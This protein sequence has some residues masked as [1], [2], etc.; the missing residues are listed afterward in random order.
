MNPCLNHLY[1]CRRL[2]RYVNANCGPTADW[3][4]DIVF[5]NEEDEREFST[6]WNTFVEATNDASPILPQIRDWDGAAADPDCSSRLH[7]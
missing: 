3:P 7:D 4:M 1:A 2:I 6:I 5:D